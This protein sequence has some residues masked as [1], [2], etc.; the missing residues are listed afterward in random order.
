MVRMRF[1]VSARRLSGNAA[2]RVDCDIGRMRREA[3]SFTRTVLDL[4][5]VPLVSLSSLDLPRG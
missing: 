5:S 4:G 3:I 1:H 2:A